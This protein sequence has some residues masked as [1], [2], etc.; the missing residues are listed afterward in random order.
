MKRRVDLSG[1]WELAMDETCTWHAVDAFANAQP[2]EIR[3]PDSTSHAGKGN[4]NP[5]DELE[6]LTESRKFE[7]NAWFRR[8]MPVTFCEGHAYRIFLERT[9]KT[10]VFVDGEEIGREES[11]CT[12]HVF[13]IPE[14]LAAAIRERGCVTLMICVSNTGYSMPGGHMTSPDTQTNWNGI[15][16]RMEIQEIP[17]V[18]LEELR[19]EGNAA[20]RSFRITGCVIRSDSSDESRSSVGVGMPSS[21]AAV[22]DAV[23]CLRAERMEGRNAIASSIVE[24]VIESVV[25]PVS[26]ESDLFCIDLELGSDAALWSEHHPTLYRVTVSIGEDEHVFLTGLRDFKSNG[27]QFTVN[28]EPVHLR[29]R[30]DGMVFPLTGYAPMEVN[31]WLRH[32][33]IAREYGLNHVRFH[34]CCPPE[35]AFQA[36]DELGMYLQ[37]ELSVW[38]TLAAPG[39]DGYDEAA[40]T[41]L[42]REGLRLQACFGH[43]PS[44]CMMSLGNELWGSPARINEILGILKAADGRHLFTQGSNNFQFNPVILAE[45]DFFSGV[46]LGR[47]RL[48]R[49]SYAMCD[50]PQGHVQ[51]SPPSAHHCYD[52]AI[53]PA[54]GIVSSDKKNA[55]SASIGEVIEIQSGTGVAT[56][57]RVNGTDAL[58]PNVPVVSHEVGQYVFFPDFSEIEKYT[59]VLEPRN[60]LTFQR[61]MQEA[62]LQ[63]QAE[64]YFLAA[65]RLAV[66]CYKAEI[67]T[68]LRSK[69]LAGFQLLDL[70]DFPGQGTA[71]VGILNAFMESKGLIAAEAWREFCSETVLLASFDGYVR[72]CGEQVPIRIDLYHYGAEPVGPA[73]ITACL[74]HDG[75][76]VWKESHAFD[77]AERGL[78]TI[79]SMMAGM[80]ELSVPGPVDLLVRLTKNGAEIAR[81]QYR[82]WAYPDAAAPLTGQLF[83]AEGRASLVER[84]G[85]RLH[86]VS[87]FEQ[88][89]L[90]LMQGERVLLLPE[91]PS[92]D[93]PQIPGTYCTDFWCYPMFRRISESMG[94]PIPVGTLGLA[95]ET[96]HP[97][98]NGF[99]SEMHATPQWYRLVSHSFCDVL[100]NPVMGDERGDMDVDGHAPFLREHAIVSVIDNFERNHRLSVL[101]ETERHGGKL[102]VCTIRLEEIMEHPEVRAFCESI[103]EYATSQQF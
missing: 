32:F 88:A 102:L 49:G 29:G 39:E 30:H 23:L 41:Q 57:Q 10:V 17:E 97:A 93:Q 51:T 74:L 4:W 36:A 18:H 20:S 8:T 68:A 16:G 21:A 31:G 38:C 47:D 80:P 34:T 99:P 81:N 58:V 89:R 87:D 19:V 46:R 35:A 5:V 24:S 40:Q 84:E 96:S 67:E 100:K 59:G 101:Y 15:L 69:R 37:P 53:F 56:V 62:G 94:K 2:E 95:I 3:L 90:L 83:P 61:R 13:E 76:T 75:E 82:F 79:C 66:D 65:G 42:I 50:A 73:V 72:R 52:E 91:H 48:I 60:L 92:T 43:H 86:V 14:R 70:Q 55:D 78:S 54:S 12:P 63:E 103:L 98:L 28:G 44:F 11:L 7:G 33:S 26:R 64:R 25:E 85:R 6:C 22:A 77:C 1:M 27:Q 71:L 9:R 45:D